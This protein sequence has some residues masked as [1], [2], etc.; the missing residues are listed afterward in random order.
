MSGP[1]LSTTPVLA[2][3]SWFRPPILRTRKAP[4]LEKGFADVMI[5]IAHLK[6]VE[7]IPVREQIEPISLNVAYQIRDYVTAEHIRSVLVV[8]AGF[9]A[10]RASLIYEAILGEAG[11]A[12]SCVPVFGRTTPENWIGTWH[13]IQE[14]VLQ[15]LKLTYYRIYVLPFERARRIR[16]NPNE[17]STQLPAR[18][19]FIR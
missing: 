13:G 3:V 2:P 8:T 17:V 18:S 16:N 12:V 7:M 1:P 5:R 9:R 19:N 10:K 15:F 6:N 4:S 11:V 14:V